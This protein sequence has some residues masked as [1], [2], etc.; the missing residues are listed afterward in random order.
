[1][2]HDIS[3]WFAVFATFQST[4]PRRVW[5]ISG[6]RTASSICFNPHTHEGCDL[7]FVRFLSVITGFNP[8]THEG[9]DSREGDVI[10]HEIKFQSTHPRRV[11][12]RSG[13]PAGGRCSVSIHTPTKGVTSFKKFANKTKKF[14]STHPRRVWQTTM[15]SPLLHLMFQSTHP[16]RVWRS[17]RLLLIWYSSV[18][19]HTPTK[20]VT[21]PS[22]RSEGR[23]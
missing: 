11:W 5:L 7:D 12:L 18:S 17:Y 8:H 14:Q 13:Q 15:T 6:A 22:F 9:C 10:A 2:W 4:H 20:G 19:I 16:R 21:L 3:I 23:R 1:M